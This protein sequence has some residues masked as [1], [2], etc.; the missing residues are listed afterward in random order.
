MATRLSS[1]VSVV[2][3]SPET[4]PVLEPVS[5]SPVSVPAD[6]VVSVA[7][8]APEVVTGAASSSELLQPARATAA[9]AA[10]IAAS[11]RRR[12]RIGQA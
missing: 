3:D 7:V 12:V 1:A 4:G 6:E 8:V 10:A 5:V 9:A 2:F 11:C